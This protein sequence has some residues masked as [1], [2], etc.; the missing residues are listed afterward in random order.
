MVP[1]EGRRG[2]RF[3]GG[4]GSFFC[5]YMK[6]PERIKCEIMAECGDLSVAAKDV[7]VRGG[8]G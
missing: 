7:V 2:S 5:L 3:V 1:P 8:L 6:I 4:R